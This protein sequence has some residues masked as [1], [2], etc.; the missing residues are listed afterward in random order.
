[1]EEN[2]V[3]WSMLEAHLSGDQR[4]CGLGSRGIVRVNWA[5]RCWG[6]A[7]AP[8][9]MRRTWDWRQLTGGL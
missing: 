7:A 9:G 8:Q 5:K 4:R 2:W 1:M 3:L 6:G